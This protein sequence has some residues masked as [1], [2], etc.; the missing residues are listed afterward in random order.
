MPTEGNNVLS[1]SAVG[2]T[3]IKADYSNYGL[4]QA[5]VAAPGGF[6]RD[7]LGDATRNR[8]NENMILAAYPKAVAIAHEEIDENGEPTTAAV[9]KS[10]NGPTCAYYQWIQG[11]SMATPH[12]VGVIALIVS[13]Y[14][15]HDGRRGLT[16][17]PAKVEKI[18]FETA[19]ATPCPLSGEVDYVPYGR[20]WVNQCAGDIDFNAFYGHGIVNALSAVTR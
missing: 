20:T 14:G 2:P 4:E 15:H 8:K 7:Y 18:L 5:S 3:G 12:A 11:T 19:T 6:F 9:V 16:L 10:C 17:S 1:I 13:Q